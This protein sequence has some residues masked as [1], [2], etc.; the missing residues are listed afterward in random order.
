MGLTAKDTYTLHTL[1]FSHLLLDALKT[2][3][4]DGVEEEF[5]LDSHLECLTLH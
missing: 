4:K 1:Q 5:I 3:A 2:A